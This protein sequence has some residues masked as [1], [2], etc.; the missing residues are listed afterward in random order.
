MKNYSTKKLSFGFYYDRPLL[1]QLNLDRFTL[2]TA[3]IENFTK[4]RYQPNKF[5]H[6]R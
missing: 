1:T 2:Q 3:F 4:K 5:L 6:F